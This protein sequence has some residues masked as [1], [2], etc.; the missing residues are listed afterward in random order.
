MYDHILICNLLQLLMQ[1]IDENDR[2]ISLVRSDLPDLPPIIGEVPFF[3][4]VNHVLAITASSEDE[5]QLLILNSED[6]IVLASEF[7]EDHAIICENLMST[8]DLT[9]EGK[10]IPGIE[11]DLSD[12]INLEIKQRIIES[13]D[14]RTE[15]RFLSLCQAARSG[16]SDAVVLLARQGANLDQSDYDGRGSIHIA[17]QEGS[18]KVVEVL[19]QHG[20]LVNSFLSVVSSRDTYCCLFAHCYKP[21]HKLIKLVGKCR[22]MQLHCKHILHP[23]TSFAEDN[24]LYMTGHF[25]T[26]VRVRECV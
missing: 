22:C 10:Q 23:C 21:Q 19:V 14:A 1:V 18:L 11:D 12:Q 16:D 24:H 7:P 3:L 26:F 2:V 17:C 8:F 5:V 13:M 25:L 15:Q 20:A 4:R 9:K 6:S